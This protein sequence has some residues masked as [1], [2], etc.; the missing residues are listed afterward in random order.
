[1]N[2]TELNPTQRAQSSAG[3]VADA[4]RQPTQDAVHPGTSPSPRP[5]R[6]LGHVMGHAIGE[7]PPPLHGNRPLGHVVGRG[8]PAS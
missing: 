3:S 7:P 2:R 1:M 8:G 6:P 5:P 4:R